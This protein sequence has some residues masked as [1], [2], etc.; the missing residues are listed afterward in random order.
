[1]TE[2]ELI[3]T[4]IKLVEHANDRDADGL[5]IIINAP[6]GGKLKCKFEYEVIPPKGYKDIVKII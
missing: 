2:M 5:K 6:D 1:M 3:K 4:F